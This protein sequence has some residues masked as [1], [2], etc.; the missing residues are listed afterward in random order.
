MHE[1]RITFT[2]KNNT[3]YLAASGQACS[4]RVDSKTQELDV[5]TESGILVICADTLKR[6]KSYVYVDI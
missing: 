2:T 6:P 4:E 1:N 3:I 5:R